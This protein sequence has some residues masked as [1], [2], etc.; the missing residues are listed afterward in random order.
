MEGNVGIKERLQRKAAQAGVPIS[1]TFEL[2][3]RCN[4]SC[5]M[6]YIRMTPEE[7]KPYGRELTAQEWISLGEQA[8]QSGMRF[9]LLTG[10]EPMLR[11]DFSEIYNAMSY[12]G[13][14]ISINTN[15]TMLSEQVRDLLERRPPSQLNVT[16]YGPREETYGTLCGNSHAFVKTMDTLRWARD[17]GILLN[18]NVTVTPWNMDQIIELEALAER[19]NLLLRQ[20]YY[21]FPPSRRNAKTDFSR[22]APED[23][24]RMIAQREYRVQ[25][26]EK[27]AGRASCIE[28]SMQLLPESQSPGISE[29]EGIR[30]Y[31]GRSQFWIA[32]NGEMT[33]CGMLDV[34]KTAPLSEGFQ[35]S[36]ERIK[37]ET[38]KIRLCPD[39]VTCKERDTCFNC[40]AV[41]RTETGS[42]EG[43][44][45]YMCRL[46]H[47]Y[48]EEVV[49][50]SEN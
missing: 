12:M 4:L 22:I 40:A 7:M 37:Q 8:T 28:K 5:R 15:G 41:V 48:R 44:P 50:L 34:P 42:Y 23:V 10:G 21:N 47:A 3:P 33:P 43:R 17:L 29:G 13:L 9:L 49:L 6:C 25:G 30:C 24:G 36:W 19:E 32:W 16:L 46:N 39:C 11:P 31:A 26:A 14:S 20:T 18:V 27:L 35:S 2:T 45:D 38:A 1:G